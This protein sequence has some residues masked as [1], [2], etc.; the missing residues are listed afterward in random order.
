M[1][2]HPPL[3]VCKCHSRQVTVL[4]GQP[5]WMH[6][7]PTTDCRHQGWTITDFSVS[8]E[9]RSICEQPLYGIILMILCINKSCV[10]ITD[11]NLQI[12]KKIPNASGH[13]RGLFAS[14]RTCPSWHNGSSLGLYALNGYGSMSSAP[15]N[16]IT[17]W[18]VENRS[19]KYEAPI[20][21]A[22][23][24]N[25][26]RKWKGR[27]SVPKNGSPNWRDWILCQCP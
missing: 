5:Q 22:Q 21:T 15:T 25:H 10:L 12:L 4:A 3:L 20:F 19:P 14:R 13:S 23:T 2:P 26:W 8:S 7:R 17:C 27:A 11:Q 18:H 1:R 16:T 9:M 6:S 24:R